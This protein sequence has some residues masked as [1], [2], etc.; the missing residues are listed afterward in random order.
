MRRRWITGVMAIVLAGCGSAGSP[1]PS[2]PSG[3]PATAAAVTPGTT[4]APTSALAPATDAAGQPTAT[5]TAAPTQ[6]PDPTAAPTSSA[7]PDATAA[8]T[9]ATAILPVADCEIDDATGAPME[10][11]PG[12]LEATLPANLLSSMTWY[13]SGR[14]AAWL[15]PAGWT[16]EGLIAGNGTS[17]FLLTDPNDDQSAITYIDAAMSY[18]YVLEIACPLFPDA[19]KAYKADFGSECAARP[20]DESI[21]AVSPTLVRFTDPPNVTGTGDESGRAYAATGAIFHD[22]NT[23][24]KMTCVLPDSGATACDAL[25]NAFVAIF[26]E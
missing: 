13:W 18:A 9:P 6:R 17:S 7:T 2:A 15:G 11:N 8:T 16:C 3:S 4:A 21:E 25:V 26:V 1:V 14:G 23:S 12:T 10:P 5:P 24:L 22:E 20:A 19:A